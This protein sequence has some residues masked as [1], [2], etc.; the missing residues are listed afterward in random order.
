MFLLKK[1]FNS[2]SL[3]PLVCHL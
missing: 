1:R 2:K 3:R